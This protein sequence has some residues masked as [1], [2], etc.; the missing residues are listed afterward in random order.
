MRLMPP[1][2]DARPK[3]VPILSETHISKKGP[4]YDNFII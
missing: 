1:G 4:S 2:P 3:N